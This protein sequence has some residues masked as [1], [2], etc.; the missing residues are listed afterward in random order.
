[1]GR[2][3]WRQGC[4]QRS[5][6]GQELGFLEEQREEAAR[7][8]APQDLVANSLLAPRSLITTGSREA[9]GGRDHGPGP[10]RGLLGAEPGAQQVAQ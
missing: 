8:G 5:P 3:S 1:M 6:W 7:E 4:G 9:R 10:V 2:G